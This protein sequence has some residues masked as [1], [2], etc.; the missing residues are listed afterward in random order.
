MPF[1]FFYLLS[2]NCPIFPRNGEGEIH[3]RPKTTSG[4]IE[5]VSPLVVGKKQIEIRK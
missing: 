3:F 1:L 5:N 4:L 2:E